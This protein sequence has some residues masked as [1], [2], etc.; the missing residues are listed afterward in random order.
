[1][2][3]LGVCPKALRTS[4]R[5]CSLSNAMAVGLTPNSGQPAQTSSQL[6][7]VIYS[8]SG[9]RTSVA[10]LFEVTWKLIWIG[11]VAIPHLVSGDMNAA[12]REVLFSC[13]F[14][15]LIIAVIPW[16]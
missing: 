7:A 12:T 14:V 13:S 2:A 5:A 10:L 11:T 4:E 8:S 1:M 15:V 9:V 3:C 16:R 6:A